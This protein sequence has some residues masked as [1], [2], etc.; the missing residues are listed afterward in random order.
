MTEKKLIVQ[1]ITVEQLELL[2]SNSIEKAL[3]QNLTFENKQDEE[4][5]SREEASKF[6]KIDISTLWSWTKKGKINVY[7]I[8]SRKYYK[9]SELIESLTLEIN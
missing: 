7:G 5:L 9:K 3:K 4:L 1:E 8:G 2:L 6:L